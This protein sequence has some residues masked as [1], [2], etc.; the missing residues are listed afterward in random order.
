M[1]QG[2][3]SSRLPHPWRSLIAPGW[4]ATNPPYALSSRAKV[5]RRGGRTSRGI[6]GCYS[7][8]SSLHPIGRPHR[9]TLPA[10]LRLTQTSVHRKEHSLS[11]SHLPFWIFSNGLRDPVWVQAFSSVLLACL[12]AATLVVLCVY[13]RD[14]HQLA[15]SSMEQ[16][17]N[18]QTPFLALV[19]IE[20]D[21]IIRNERLAALTPPTYQ[22]WAIENQGNAPAINIR[23]NGQCVPGANGKQAIISQFLNPIPSGGNVPLKVHS[24]EKIMDCQIEY[25]S[26]DGRRFRTNL[27]VENDE[28]HSTFLNL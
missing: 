25:G 23:V 2:S 12:T 15:K 1:G 22:L 3:E 24:A 10:V 17:K 9:L 27:T 7:L 5:A 20:K 18:A 14:T 16:V 8:Q 6:C 21:N 26:L 11:M 13:A 4:D 19:R 28:L